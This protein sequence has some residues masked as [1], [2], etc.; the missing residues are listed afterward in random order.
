M[1]REHT[2]MDKMFRRP[3][4]DPEDQGS[5]KR[6]LV[7]VPTPF[8]EDIQEKYSAIKDESSKLGLSAGRVDENIGAGIII[9]EITVSSSNSV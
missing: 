3:D 9:G 2:Y 6:N 7:F 8:G 1:G 5:F 4:Y